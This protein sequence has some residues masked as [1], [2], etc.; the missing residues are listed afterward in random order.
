VTL[1]NVDSIDL[2]NPER[3]YEIRSILEKKP[4]L[5]SLYREVY[6][7]YAECIQRCPTEGIALEIGSGGGFVKEIIPNIITS[8][9]LSYPNVDRVMDAT[10]FN[11]PDNSLSCICMFNVLHHI[12]NAPAFFKEVIRCLVPGG[13]VFMVEP[14]AGW[15]SSWIFRNLHHEGFDKEVKQWEFHSNG[16]VSDANNALPTVIFERDIEKFRQEFSELS[17]VK[18][19]PHTPLRYWMTGGLQNWSLLPKWAYNMGCWVDKKLIQLS[20]RLGS[21]VDIELIKV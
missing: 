18:F 3:F 8:D 13:R 7:K 20:P 1:K 19:E 21:F 11:F 15:I 10:K 5:K 2:N 14:Y 17:L 4:S 9:I 12:P 16:P 6:Q